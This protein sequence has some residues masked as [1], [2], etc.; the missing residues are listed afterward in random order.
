[1]TDKSTYANSQLYSGTPLMSGESQRI[2]LAFSRLQ[3]QGLKAVLRYQIE[4]LDFLSRRYQ[5]DIRLMDDLAA[6][7]E[8]GDMFD[9]YADF[10]REAIVEYGEEAGRLARLESKLASETAREIQE[11]SRTVSEDMAL[12]RVA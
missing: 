7:G 9:I 11:E 1:M 2:F 12:A 10:M 6:S 4:A 5:K 3:G 8:H